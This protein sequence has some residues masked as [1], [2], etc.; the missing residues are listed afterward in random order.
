MGM[1]PKT[2]DTYVDDTQPE[3][4][5]PNSAQY[6]AWG[7]ST[8]SWGFTVIPTLGFPMAAVGEDSISAFNNFASGAYDADV[9][10]VFQAYVDKGFTVLFVRFG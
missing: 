2:I 3:S 9:N 1:K 5:W 4:T 10:G 6:S 8:I 7:I